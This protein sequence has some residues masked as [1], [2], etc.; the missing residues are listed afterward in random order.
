M[1]QFIL[2]FISFLILV[3]FTGCNSGERS[4]G[5]SN[6]IR[7]KPNILFIFADDQSYS[8]IHALGNEEIHTPTLDKLANSGVTFT[9]AFNMGAWNGA[10]CV[11]SR[12]MLNTGR[13]L[14]R[15][16]QYED[17]QQ[18]LADRGEM[19]GQLMQKAGYET[20][21]TGKW[22]V[23]TDAQKLFDHV[24][25]VR[26]GMPQDAWNKQQVMT[27]IEANTKRYGLDA[28]G[29]VPVGYDT[30]MPLGYNRP[31]SPGDTTWKPWDKELGG[32]WEGGKHWSEVLADDAITFLDS[33]QKKDNPFFMYLAFNA[34]H[35][36]RQFPQEYIDMYPLENISVPETFLPEYTYRGEGTGLYPGQRDESVA[37][38]PR[39]EYAV[40]VHSQEYYAII[41]HMDRQIGRILDALEK[42]GKADNTY[43]FFTADHG[44]AVGKHGLM[45][46]QNM[47]DHSIRVPF[48]V[49]GP[50]VQENKRIDADIY[51]QDIMAS[52]L[53]I[54]GMEKPDY[55]EFN[56]F[57]PIIRGEREES[58]YPEIYGAYRTH[59]RM[60]RDDGFKLVVY[61]RIKVM[62]LYDLAGDPLEL[63]DVA[64]APEYEETKV[65]LFK[66]LLQLQKEMD[67]PTDLAEYFP[68]ITNKT[69]LKKQ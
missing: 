19:W 65:K 36:P 20:Y 56:S 63:H 10:V 54:A 32:F 58:F 67:D 51:L 30:I 7:K 47:Y 8:T 37:P 11:A 50:D 44:L 38:Y 5:D 52:A 46:K 6:E 35:D 4:T 33:A 14:W 53:D 59:Q 22:H 62:R 1:K 61:P 9:H 43:I 66:K 42:S 18:D 3:V 45:G 15:A 40:K 39:T 41:T 34:P 13:F 26:P 24:V 64:N 25:H 2:T 31:L 60:I 29:I 16:H 68:E 27:K 48:F 28:G 23:K 57:M 17:R 55:V 49:I 69:S 12:A 21:M